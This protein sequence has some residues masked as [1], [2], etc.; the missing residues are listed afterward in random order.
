MSDIVTTQISQFLDSLAT[1][2]TE[3]VPSEW[4]EY[5]SEQPYHLLVGVVV[6]YQVVSIAH[7]RLKT[8]K[9]AAELDLWK[10][11]GSVA[12]IDPPLILLLEN[13]IALLYERLPYLLRATISRLLFPYTFTKNLLM[14]ISVPG[15][16][17]Y[18]RIDE[19]GRIYLPPSLFSLS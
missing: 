10:K 12:L 18:H 6:T 17:W 16:D 19:N 4:T 15:R 1:T 14:Y 11:K 5:A 8:E 7:A 2:F 3:L 13:S 9:P